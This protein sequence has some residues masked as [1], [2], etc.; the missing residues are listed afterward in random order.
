MSPSDYQNAVQ[1][2]AVT[3]LLFGLL[4]GVASIL[5]VSAVIFTALHQVVRLVAT[6]L[7]FNL[8]ISTLLNLI[9]K[10]G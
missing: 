9:S 3:I 10:I 2:L 4:A 1:G 7:I 6:I 5:P 8:V